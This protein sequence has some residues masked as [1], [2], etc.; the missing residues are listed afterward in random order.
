[1]VEIR[2]GDKRDIRGIKT[3]DYD[4][5]NFIELKYETLIARSQET[6][7]GLFEYYGFHDEAISL[8]LDVADRLHIKNRTKRKLRRARKTQHLRSGKPGQ[9]QDYF[10]QAHKDLFKEIHGDLLVRLGY[11]PNNDW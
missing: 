8:A 1:M 4:D 6:F 10:T 3:W 2:R 5:P 11:E 7:R 9:W